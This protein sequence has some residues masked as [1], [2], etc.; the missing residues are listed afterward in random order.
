[1]TAT[2]IISRST[3]RSPLAP[4]G[5]AAQ[6]HQLLD[7]VRH[8]GDG[9]FVAERLAVLIGVVAKPLNDVAIDTLRDRLERTERGAV[10]IG[11]GERADRAGFHALGA[12][13]FRPSIDRLL[14]RGNE[15]GRP[16]Q[17]RQWH[18]LEAGAPEIEA[19]P[20]VPIDK[21]LHILRWPL[22]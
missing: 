15:L 3:L 14:I 19:R 11:D 5:L 17:A 8:H 2:F 16:G 9:A 1:L 6:L 7:V 12:D 20:A 10:V 13:L 4:S 22:H 18:R 21:G